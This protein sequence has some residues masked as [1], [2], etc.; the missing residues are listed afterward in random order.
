MFLHASTVFLSDISVVIFS[1]CGSF[2]E[3]LFLRRCRLRQTPIPS[4]Q[5]SHIH[6]PYVY[7][8]AVYTGIRYMYVRVV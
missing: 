8:H 3:G 2:E 5:A 4:L 7:N 6:L 1:F